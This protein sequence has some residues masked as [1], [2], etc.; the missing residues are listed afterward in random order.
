MFFDLGYDNLS[1]DDDYIEKAVKEIDG[2]FDLVLITEYFDESLI[3]LK[4]MLGWSWEDVVYIK[5]NSRYKKEDSNVH[6][7]H[8]KMQTR[9]WTKAD[10]FLYDYFNAALCRKI[11]AYGVERMN[12]DLLELASRN[13]QL[14]DTC[15]LSVVKNADVEDSRHK[16]RNCRGIE[17]TGYILKPS[18]VNNALCQ[19]VIRSEKSWFK[20]F[21]EKQAT[22]SE[23]EQ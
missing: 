9:R 14:Q 7:D 12:R 2:I 15:I 1:E 4:E 16:V 11:S 19:N 13:E 3:L 17:L 22:P 18:A 21:A 5:L 10:T 20:Y 8:L 6:H 23:N